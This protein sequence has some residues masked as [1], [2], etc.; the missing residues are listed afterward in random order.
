[1]R[2]LFISLILIFILLSA[3]VLATYVISISPA[4]S[5]LCLA[6][7][8]TRELN[9]T[10]WA[11]YPSDFEIYVNGTDWISAP[12][13]LHVAGST[14]LTVNATIPYGAQNGNY[15]DN[16]MLVCLPSETEGMAVKNC[17]G[18]RIDLSVDDSCASKS[19]HFFMLFVAGVI[20]LFFGSRV[21]KII[22]KSR[23]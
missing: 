1:M 7:G 13:S 19:D 2:P 5:S 3:P 14:A 23:K 20:C 4:S 15:T 11:E 8:E 10:V 9:F 17:L 21:S 6:P 12:S 18:V 22:Y 16:M